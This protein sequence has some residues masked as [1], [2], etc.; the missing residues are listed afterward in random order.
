[1]SLSAMLDS[2]TLNTHEEKQGPNQAPKAKA[3]ATPT[4]T[5]APVIL[6]AYDI[7]RQARKSKEEGN[8]EM[9]TSPVWSGVSAN[10]EHNFSF[11]SSTSPPARHA[12]STEPAKQAAPAVLP[13]WEIEKQAKAAK[14]GQATAATPQQWS[15]LSAS[16]ADEHNQTM[17][18]AASPEAPPRRAPSNTNSTPEVKASTPSVL[19]KWEIEKQVAKTKAGGARPSYEAPTQWCGLSS[20]FANEHNQTMYGATS[21]E[22]PRPPS[23]AALTAAAPAP[24][25]PAVLPIFEIEKAAQKAKAEK[26]ARAANSGSQTSF[27]WRGLSNELN[28]SIANVPSPQTGRRNS[29]AG[30]SALEIS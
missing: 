20:S 29:I 13:K 10:D 16:F 23:L 9:F 27:E 22:A 15:G 18:G 21:P 8:K 24:K 7:A 1:M 19:P 25:A 26:A 28:D 6:P 4:R 5:E 12:K 17:Y 3:T 2:A 11:A 30:R 14:G